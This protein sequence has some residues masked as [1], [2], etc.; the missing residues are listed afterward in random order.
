MKIKFSARSVDC[1]S[2]YGST[3][4]TTHAKENGKWA[5][6]SRINL[7]RL[8]PVAFELREW[9]QSDLA[10]GTENERERA[11]RYCGIE[12][13]TND[14]IDILSEIKAALEQE[15]IARRKLA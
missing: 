13:D 8:S 5:V 11:K 10:N 6:I 14:A 7:R 9:V 2:G 1:W 12:I 4:I 3:A 15:R